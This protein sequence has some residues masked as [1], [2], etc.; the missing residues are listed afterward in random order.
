MCAEIF[1]PASSEV[2]IY[3]LTETLIFDASE[4]IRDPI[5]I[6]MFTTTIYY[7]PNSVNEQQRRSFRS[8]K[9][10]FLMYIV[11]LRLDTALEEVCGQYIT[12]SSSLAV[13]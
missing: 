2:S 10:H 7:N 1:R 12:V 13:C 5:E 6:K 11:M 4:W 8:E 9:R 3:F